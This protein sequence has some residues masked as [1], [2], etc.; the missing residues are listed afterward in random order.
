MNDFYSDQNQQQLNLARVSAQEFSGL[1]LYNF[2][3]VLNC[4]DEL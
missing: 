1:L 4:S 3:D 2:E